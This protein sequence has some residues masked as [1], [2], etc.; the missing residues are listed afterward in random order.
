M[1]WHVHSRW[2]IGKAVRFKLIQSKYSEECK[3]IIYPG[4]YF[5]YKHL[6][7]SDLQVL[8]LNSRIL[9]PYPLGID[10][11]LDMYRACGEVWK[12]AGMVMLCYIFGA[13]SC[14]LVALIVLLRLLMVKWPLSYQ[15]VHKSVS[16][17]GCILIWVVPL[18]VSSTKFI[19]S[20]PV[21]YDANILKIFTGIENYG[22]MTAPILLTVLLYVMLLCSL[23]TQTAARITTHEA[24]I[25]RMK[26]LAKMTHGV[27][28]SLIVCNV[29]N[30]VYTAYVGALIGYG[31]DDDVFTSNVSVCIVI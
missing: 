10:G 8:A 27:V 7:Y 9:T 22:L 5:S 12:A 28:A 6:F 14:F 25:T 24:T 21:F 17:N 29:P 2:Y 11:T 30:L 20:L 19:V 13:T 1:C 16:R 3:N 23:K 26:A 18:L 31:I 4:N 15:S